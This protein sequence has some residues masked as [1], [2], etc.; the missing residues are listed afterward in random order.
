[1]GEIRD[2]KSGKPPSDGAVPRRLAAIVAGDIAGYSRL[3]QLDEEGTHNRV[4]R[5]LRDLIE[6]TIAEHHGRLV[7]TTGDGFIAMFDSP[8]EAVRFSI[9]IQQNLVGRNAAV[10]K[11]FWIEYRIGVNLGDIIIEPEDIYGDGV[12]VAARL[13]GI[14][15]PGEVFISGGIYEQIKHKLVCGYE[16]LGD[17]RVK[18]ITDPVRVYRV[19]PDVAAYS[20]TR[21]RRENVLISLLGLSIAIIAGGALWYLLVQP[22]GNPREMV[23]APSSSPAPAPKPAEPAPAAEPVAP[24]QAQSPVPAP[25]AQQSSAQPQPAPSASPA[26]PALAAAAPEPEMVSLTGGSFA[27]GSNDDASERPIHRVTVK[28]FAMG[29]YPVTVREWNACAAAKG[30]GFTATGN[31]DA[32]VTNVSWSDAKQ[33]V[34]WLADS[35]KKPYRLPSEAE[36]EYAARGGTQTRYWWGDQVQPGVASCKDCGGDAAAE[37]PVKVGSFRPNPFGLYDMGGGVDQW[38]EDCWHRNY[39][40]APADGTARHDGDCFSHVIRS[41]SWKNDAR[42]MRPANRDNYDTNVRY[43]TH[44]FRV[45]LSL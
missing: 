3:M 6:P 33:Y 4:K 32:P 35:T 39:Q 25:T 11:E 42:Y 9:V 14:A 12:N 24:N 7:K 17:R 27:M 15:D 21:R 2:F 13:E 31:D 22:R 18:N 36:W 8:V 38:V 1:M 34:T 45:A 37:Q 41:G 30:C 23:L 43:P 19:L 40:G 44:G 5:I 20:R 26:G 16:S 29:K 10:P 28:P